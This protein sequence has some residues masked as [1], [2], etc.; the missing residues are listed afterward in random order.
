MIQFTLFSAISK[1]DSK[2]RV[3]IPV[4]LRWK[5]RLTEGSCVK[6]LKRKNSLVLVPFSEEDTLEYG[7]GSVKVSTRVCETLRPGSI[8]GSGLRKL[9]RGDKSAR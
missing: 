4:K 9:N 2:G 6:I 3:S 1:I 5:L 8:L 7:Q